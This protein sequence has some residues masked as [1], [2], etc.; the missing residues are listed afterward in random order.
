MTG[1][2]RSVAKCG[3]SCSRNN[4]SC[5]RRRASPTKEWNV[6]LFYYDVLPA[7]TKYK[8][9]RLKVEKQSPK[10]RPEYNEESVT[11][12]SLHKLG[13]GYEM[14]NRC[15]SRRD[16]K[17]ATWRWCVQADCSRHEQR[18]LEKLGRRR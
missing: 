7:A 11:G 4:Q 14:W 17:T 3:V 12:R 10:N 2:A 18:R 16:R 1:K 5:S 6:L 13:A 15:V 8:N 9:T